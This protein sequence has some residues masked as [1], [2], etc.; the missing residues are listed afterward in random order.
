MQ[1]EVHLSVFLAHLPNK[2]ASV[3]SFCRAPS[4]A[5]GD[6]V[7]RRRGPVIGQILMMHRDRGRGGNVQGAQRLCRQAAVHGSLG[8]ATLCWS[9]GEW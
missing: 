4:W 3:P 2:C 6:T 7:A 5:L 9:R 1:G 8:E